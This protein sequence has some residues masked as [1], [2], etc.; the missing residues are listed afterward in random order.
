MTT[1][2]IENNNSEPTEAIFC[3]GSNCGDRE[4]NVAKALSWLTGKM[5]YF[6]H[7]TIYA[8]PDCH[9]GQREYM[10]AVGMGI[11]GLTSASLERLCKEYETSC[12][13][14][15]HARSVGDVPIDVD[16]VVFD[17]VILRE[18]DYGSE[19]FLKGLRE[20]HHHAHSRSD[21]NG[22]SLLL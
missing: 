13:R 6:S 8:T 10:N 4:G 3:I 9:G 11:T 15:S 16:V 22:V 20:I 17:G 12:G 2:H 19:F 7:S 1:E 14:D 21:A 5:S 18:R